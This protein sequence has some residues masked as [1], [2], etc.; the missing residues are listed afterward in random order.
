[1]DRGRPV[2]S[3]RDDV[4]LAIVC[5]AAPT[6]NAADKKALAVPNRTP[7]RYQFQS[8]V[9]REKDHPVTIAFYDSALKPIATSEQNVIDHADAT[10]RQE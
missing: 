8:R 7:T 10:R 5:I 4:R 9:L 2:A 3:R 6:L 1:M